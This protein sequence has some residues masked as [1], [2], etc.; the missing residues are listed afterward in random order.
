MRFYFECTTPPNLGRGAIFLEFWT[1]C[2]FEHVEGNINF[3]KFKIFFPLVKQT[4]EFVV[5]SRIWNFLILKKNR[6]LLRK[7]NTKFKV[8]FSAWEWSTSIFILKPSKY[9]VFPKAWLKVVFSYEFDCHRYLQKANVKNSGKNF[10][11][12]KAIFFLK[13]QFDNGKR[14][15]ESKTTFLKSVPSND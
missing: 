4:K 3:R 15:F 1:F 2:V 9:N 14:F 11:L 5:C 10:R 7:T 8:F 13:T 12:E 6:F